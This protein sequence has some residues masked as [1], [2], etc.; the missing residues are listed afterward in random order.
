MNTPGYKGHMAKT[1]IRTIS[2]TYTNWPKESI[3]TSTASPPTLRCLVR[4]QRDAGAMFQ[5]I[6]PLS[7]TNLIASTLR[8]H[9]THQDNTLL[10]CLRDKATH[11]TDPHTYKQAYCNFTPRR[12]HTPLLPC[13]KPLWQDNITTWSQVL[14]RATDT[15]IL[16]Q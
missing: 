10:A 8:A 1:H 12:A 2:T 15:S 14:L 7:L 3:M 13:L 9:F 5:H 11:I 16:L 4:A 6:P